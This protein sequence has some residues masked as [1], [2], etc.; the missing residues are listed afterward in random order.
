MLSF[1]GYLA[2][3]VNS[4]FWGCKIYSKHII[5]QQSYCKNFMI[6]AITN[7]PQ[8]LYKLTILS[9]RQHFYELNKI[10]FIIFGH[11]H[12]L[13]LINKDLLRNGIIK[14]F[15]FSKKKENQFDSVAHQSA[16]GA[17][18][19]ARRPMTGRPARASVFCRNAPTLFANSTTTSVLFPQS[20]LIE[21]DPR[22]N[23]SLQRQ[24]PWCPR[25]RRRDIGR[26]C[27]ATPANR[28]SHRHI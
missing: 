13:I 3:L 11:L 27:A 15:L 17:R 18:P 4:L 2:T 20:A 16:T 8:K 23:S 5:I 19:T 21:E 22:T 1:S 26:H 28:D 7:F 14:L 6:N 10:Y 25:T 12:E 9:D 24:D